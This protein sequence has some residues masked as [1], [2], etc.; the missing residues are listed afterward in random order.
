MQDYST[1]PVQM[2]QLVTQGDPNGIIMVESNPHAETGVG[3]KKN[4]K[5]KAKT[6]GTENA[7]RE[8]NSNQAD[9]IVTLKNPMFFN[10]NNPSEP[11]NS[12]MR[13]IQTPPFVSPMA[14][15]PTSASIVRNENGMYTIRNPSFQNAFGGG[16]SPSPAYVPRPTA[17]TETIVRPF[18]PPSYGAFAAEQTPSVEVS[19]PKCSSVIGSEMKNVLQRRKEQEFAAN[20]DSY[21]QY[22]IRTPAAYSH[23]GGS[24]VNFNNNGTNCD[25]SFLSQQAAS[26]FQPYQS[27]TMLNY[28]DLRL[29]PGQMLN[30]EVMK[31]FEKQLNS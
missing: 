6:D 16:A 10:N 30:S 4:K 29:T 22:G 25:E 23:F 14:P 3:K 1:A 15:E 31:E 11:I 5:K 28:D 18:A 8:T 26:G 19:H 2:T 27:P 12:M 21:N 24:G 20:M 13:N 9:R 7:Q 17:P